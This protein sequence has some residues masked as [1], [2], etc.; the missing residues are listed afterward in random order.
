MTRSPYRLYF[1]VD[2]Q[3]I[4]GAEKSLDKW[5][6]RAAGERIVRKDRYGRV[7]EDISSTDSHAAYKL[8]LEYDERP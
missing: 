6:Y 7:I 1:N 8:A 5:L 3:G 2:S 4:E